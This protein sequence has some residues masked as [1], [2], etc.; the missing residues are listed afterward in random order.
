MKKKLSFIIL[1]YNTP[2]E[3]L[4]CVESIQKNVKNK[5]YSIVIVDNHSSKENLELFDKLFENKRNLDILKLKENVGFSKGNNAGFE[6]AKKKYDPEFYYIINNDTIISQP[7]TIELIEE[8]Y[9]ESK[10][11]YMGPDVI[12]MEGKHSSPINWNMNLMSPM[13]VPLFRAIGSFILRF[14][15]IYKF[16]KKREQKRRVNEI[17]TQKKK[18]GIGLQ[19]AALIFS[20]KCFNKLPRPFYP[21]TFLY[22]EEPILNYNRLKYNLK[23]IYNPKIKILHKEDSSIGKPINNNF[24]KLYFK[25]GETIKSMNTYYDYKKGKLSK[26]N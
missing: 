26:Q 4:E 13:I 17:E 25:L 7:N 6:Y 15:H 16:F 3:T 14:T 1:Q 21:E 22:F 18:E 12:N 24:K 5:N 9:K 19:G 20:R 23:N 11:D 8:E 2:K 10:F